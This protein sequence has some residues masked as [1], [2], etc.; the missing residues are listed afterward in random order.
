MDFLASD[1]L[2]GRGSGTQDELIAATY[3]ASQLEQYGVEPAGDNG[4]YIQRGTLVHRKLAAP[5]TLSL[6]PSGSQEATWTQ[7]KEFVPVYLG[8]D[9]FSGPLQKVRFDEKNKPKLQPNAVVFLTSKNE[10]EYR[11]AAFELADEGAVAVLIPEDQRARDRWQSLSEKL[12]DLPTEI[13]GGGTSGMTTQVAV[14]ALS[15]EAVKAMEQIPDGT[16]VSFE[17]QV[18]PAEK[19]YTWNALGIIRGRDPGLSRAAILLSAHLDHLGV[20]KPVNGDSIYNGADDDASG[21]T[22]VLELARVLGS[23]PKPRRTVL[24]ALFGS[25]EAG[26]LG[27]SYFLQHPPVPLKDIAAN[28]EFEMIGRADPK[29]PREANWLTGW[30]RSNLG[31]VLAEHGANLVGDPRPDEGFFARSDNIVL[32]KKGVVAQ[33]VSSFAVHKDYHQPSDDLAHIDFVHMDRAIGSMLKPVLWLVN[34]DFSPKWKE[35]KQP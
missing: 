22:A 5:A 23:G 15:Q 8:R 13:E 7:G 21:T 10:N 27:S 28:L 1:S 9:S 35:G 33:T 16:T 12:P 32:A 20:G 19:T 14:F 31:P 6:H 11:R 17:P 18:A 29:V 26:G 3:V 2:R 30:E 24:F 34:S 25:E 4:T